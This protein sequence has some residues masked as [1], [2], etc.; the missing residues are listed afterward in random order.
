MIK[1]SARG[2]GKEEREETSF[3]PSNHP[4][5]FFRHASHVFSACNSNRD[6]WE[7]VS[8]KP[9]ICWSV[10]FCRKWYLLLHY[11]YSR[12]KA[13][14]KTHLKGTQGVIYACLNGW[15]WCHRN[16]PI[17]GQIIHIFANVMQLWSQIRFIY[18]QWASIANSESRI[19]N[20]SEVYC[21]MCD[22]IEITV[23]IKKRSPV[24]FLRKKKTSSYSLACHCFI[25]IL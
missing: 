7:L 5:T 18:H 13:K 19:S 23:K 20:L 10:D 11:F 12:I 3:P 14:R 16:Y 24:H 4:R 1:E 15:F 22:V 9:A 6:T 2:D 21:K 8:C 17:R 25:V